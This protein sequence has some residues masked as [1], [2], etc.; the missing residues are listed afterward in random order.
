MQHSGIF[1]IFG[2]KEQ[3]FKNLMLDPA[4][5][6]EKAK[7]SSFYLWILNKVLDRVIPFNLPHGFRILE[8]SDTHIKTKIP[9]K[10]K[11]KNHIG[12]L[13]ACAL[14]TL[15]EF[16]TGALMLTGLDPKKFRLILKNL[17]VDYLYQGKTDAYATYRLSP[18]FME[19]HIFTPLKSAASVII[20]CEVQIHDRMGNH[21][22]TARV[23]WQIK[24]WNKVKTGKKASTQAA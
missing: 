20:P 10:R 16:T 15:S 22:T 24:E 2:T 23:H 14:A 7:T 17:E 18:E 9:F 4:S 5:L 19:E 1:L 3:S 21:L 13:H 6:L 11:N 8:I 12:G